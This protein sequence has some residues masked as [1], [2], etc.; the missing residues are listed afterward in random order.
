MLLLPLFILFV[1]ILLPFVTASGK[2]DAGFAPKNLQH[3]AAKHAGDYYD[4]MRKSYELEEEYRASAVERDK[5]GRIIRIVP[6]R[7]KS[8]KPVWE[9]S[10][11]LAQAAIQAKEEHDKLS[12]KATGIQKLQEWKVSD[13]KAVS[14]L[15]T[16]KAPK[17]K[18]GTT[19]AGSGWTSLPMTASL[20]LPK[21]PLGQPK[22]RMR[23]LP[24][25][26]IEQP[27]RS[28]RKRTRKQSKRDVPREQSK[29]DAMPPSPFQQAQH[30]SSRL[31]QASFVRPGTPKE[32]SPQ[33]RFSWRW[34]GKS[35][36][37]N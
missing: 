9:K 14:A 30:P 22:Q 8:R 15:R 16:K 34:Q 37:E 4:K 29:Q 18:T 27:R 17:G 31:R 5:W 19:A 35:W 33:S 25:S 28:K 23:S 10:R 2:G 36:D 7:D 6:H 1:S 20:E 11:E 32:E 12:G 3:L 26:Q 13:L 21:S 24:L